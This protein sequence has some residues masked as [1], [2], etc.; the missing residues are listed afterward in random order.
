M[1]EHDIPVIT[2]DG[3][4]GSGKGTVARAVASALGFHFLDSGALYRAVG[5]RALQH[6]VALDDDVGLDANARAADVRFVERGESNPWVMLDGA[7][8][9]AHLHSQACADAASR[10]AARPV[11]REVL[12]DKQ[13]AL[14]QPPG[15]V[16]DGRDMGTIVFPE[17]QV[18]VFLDAS[19]E[20]RARRRYK[21]LIEKG[22]PASMADLSRELAERDLRDRT[23]AIAP[24][25]PAADATVV[26]S[27]SMDA[28][29]VVETILRLVRQR[30]P[31]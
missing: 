28:A 17:A 24:L 26:D 23:R 29:Q 12:L 14:K 13:R 22:M 20:E 7:E 9:S 19:V 27:T 30:F 3:P 18:K 15:L 16:A 6:G 11:V 10:C 31:A 8:V 21:Q 5:L 1:Y 25:Q 2:I 4:S